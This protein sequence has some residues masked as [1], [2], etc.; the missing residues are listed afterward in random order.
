M[1]KIEK[2]T[3]KCGALKQKEDGYCHQ[4][5]GHMTSHPGEG[6]CNLHSG[7]AN[8][9]PTPSYNIPAL[10]ERMQEFIHDP[11]IISV[12]REIALQRS[13]TELL[14]HYITRLKWEHDNNVKPEDSIIN[15]SDLT[16]MINQCTRNI[17]HLVQTKHQIEMD[18]KYMI[19][20]RMVHLIFSMVGDILDKA[21]TD[22]V[23]RMKIDSDLN[24]IALPVP[25]K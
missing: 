11:E 24:R 16:T 19:D 13:Y 10:R 25:I 18:R 15:V 20:I 3:G 14:G 7:I 23:I 1:N 5:A 6:R 22:R 9:V 2:Y 4:Q 21:I 8:G 12:D 17:S